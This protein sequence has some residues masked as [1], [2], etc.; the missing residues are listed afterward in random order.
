MLPVVSLD[1]L[2]LTS[3][4]AAFHTGHATSQAYLLKFERAFSPFHQC[5]DIVLVSHQCY[6]CPLTDRWH[7][8]RP[9]VVSDRRMVNT[10]L[11]PVL[12]PKFKHIFNFLC[13][14]IILIRN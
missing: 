6:N 12:L 10:I 13:Y 3:F 14:L 8:Y 4:A 2:L 5:G 7:I 1:L 9:S 11:L